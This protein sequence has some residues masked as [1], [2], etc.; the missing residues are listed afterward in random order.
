MSSKHAAGA[1]REIKKGNFEKS[2]SL[3]IATLIQKFE[4]DDWRGA[5]ITDLI[6]LLV[7]LRGIM[8]KNSEGQAPVDAWLVSVSK[9]VDAKVRQAQDAEDEEKV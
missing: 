2:V 1:V 4:K 6:Q 3:I 9:R 8:V 7:L 5:R